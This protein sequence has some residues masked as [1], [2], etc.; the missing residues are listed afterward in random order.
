MTHSIQRRGWLQRA[1]A[2]SAALFAFGA[3]AEPA[4]ELRIGFQKSASLL[5]LQ[6]AQGTLE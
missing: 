3:H 4:K 6:K 2:L 5:V 1:L